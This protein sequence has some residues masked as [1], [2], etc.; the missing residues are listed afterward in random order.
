MENIN[1]EELIETAR[2]RTNL[3]DFGNAFFKEGLEKLVEGINNSSD[4]RRSTKDHL[5]DQI[6]LR[7][8]MNLLYCAKDIADNPDILEQ[9]LLPPITIVSMPRSGSSYLQRVLSVT[10]AFQT[11]PFWQIHMPSRIPHQADGGR[12]QRMEKT[13]D[14]LT[15]IIGEV[16]DQM[17]GHPMSV[18]GADE[19]IFLIENIFR[20]VYTESQHNSPEYREWIETVDMRPAYEYLHQ[21]LQYLQWQFYRD[22][23]KPYIL[24][25]PAHLGFENQLQGIFPK[26]QKIIMT[27]RDPIEVVG[28]TCFT[29]ELGVNQYYVDRGEYYGERV[30]AWLLRAVN[31]HLDWRDNNSDLE[32]LD[33]SFSELSNDSIGTAEKVYAFVGETLSDEGSKQIQEW[34]RKNPRYQHGKSEYSLE[35]YDLTLARV[36]EAFTPYLERFGQ[37]I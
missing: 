6:I 16:P 30:L 11:L 21:Q 24:K 19:E 34:D 9:Q 10:N 29:R 26:E 4:F 27:H 20:S 23:P 35:Q 33:L 14:F 22:R 25:A 2:Q 12:E 31:R 37:Y 8:L 7:P 13:R 1:I 5:E 15:W 17:K 32:V 18:E 28:S 36:N 3:T